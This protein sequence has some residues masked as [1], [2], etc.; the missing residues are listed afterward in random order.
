MH[1]TKVIRL[2]DESRLGIANKIADS[3]KIA[4]A[5]STVNLNLANEKS[6]IDTPH[7]ITLDVEIG[8]T[9]RNMFHIVLTPLK[10]EVFALRDPACRPLHAPVD[11]IARLVIHQVL[12]EVYKKVYAYEE[13]T[14]HLDDF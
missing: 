8:D 1:R 6:I 13:F 7:T 4:Y 9:Y 14:L 12:L 2:T 3:L 5:S 10:P 11:S